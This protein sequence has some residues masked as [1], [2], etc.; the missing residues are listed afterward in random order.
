MNGTVNVYIPRTADGELMTGPV[1]RHRL[2]RVKSVDVRTFYDPLADRN[3]SNAMPLPARRTPVP[4][5]TF[6]PRGWRLRPVVPVVVA[7]IP[8]IEV[9]PECVQF[10][11]RK[12]GKRG[13][14]KPSGLAWHVERCVMAA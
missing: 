7:L 4:P 10:A 5:T 6:A 13:F 12:C 2:P 3:L 11:C 9:D 8:E 1:S 14:R